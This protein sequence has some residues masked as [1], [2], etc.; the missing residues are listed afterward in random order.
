[1]TRSVMKAMTLAVGLAIGANAFA[2]PATDVAARVK[3]LND[4]L[5]EQ[6]QYTMKETPEFASILGD[7]R[8]NDRFSDISLA[9]VVVQRKDTEKF[10]ARFK[11]IDTNGFGEQDRLNQQLMV[12]QLADHVRAIDL[13]LH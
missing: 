8:Y 6:W 4:L 12:R 11:A 9:H 13:K 2:A 1:M 7:Y 3:A 10:L 5:A